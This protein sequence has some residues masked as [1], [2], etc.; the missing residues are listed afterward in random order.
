MM[1]KACEINTYSRAHRCALLVKNNRI[2]FSEALRR[3][4]KTFAFAEEYLCEWPYA[5]ANNFAMNYFWFNFLINW[6]DST[7]YA[8]YLLEEELDKL[9]NFYS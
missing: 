1:H 6:N 9:E 5:L 7:R 3:I 4:Q 2:G 8:W